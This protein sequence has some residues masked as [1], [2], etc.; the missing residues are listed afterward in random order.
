MN[1]FG[2]GLAHTVVSGQP[3]A[4]GAKVALDAGLQVAYPSDFPSLQGKPTPA[5]L[6][7]LARAMQSFDLV[8]TYNWG[9]M[10]AVLAHRLYGAWMRLP[11]L[12]HHEDGFNHDEAAGLKRSRNVFRRV[13][14]GRAS[15][16][17]VPSQRLEAIALDV[18]K[19][20][21]DK[22]RLIINGIATKAYQ[23]TS[24]S[25]SVPGLVK[26]SGEKWL[27]TLAGLR[28][29]KNL[30]RMVRAFAQMPPEWRLVILGEGPERAAIE[31]QAQ[32]CGIA[33][34]VSLPGFIPN[35]SR[36]VG[37][38]DLFA[39][40]SDSEQFPISVLEAMAAGIAV[41]S[42]AVGDVAQM[43]SVENQRFVTPVGDE[44]GLA[45]SLVELGADAPLRQVIGNAN[46]ARAQAQFDE[47]KMI[48]AY[49]V[50]YSEVM[51]ITHF[52]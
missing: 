10:D 15:A 52:P 38:F 40:S 4:Y 18:W 41:V 25:D 11:P 33:D 27:G 49:A 12:V 1:V 22:V 36:A 29:V 30:P 2:N 7:A 14:L 42:P 21:R 20:P 39:L 45:R 35:P 32:A 26:S 6:H 44:A 46:Q 19:Q 13:A 24:P 23:E 43:V 37:L 31:A 51:G 17:V 34:R 28:P 8:L 9:A 48:S 3:G 5:R 47:A 50:T 16:V